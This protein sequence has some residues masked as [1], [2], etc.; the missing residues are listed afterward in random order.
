ME[1]HTAP[2]SKKIFN[3]KNNIFESHLCPGYCPMHVPCLASFNP[4]NHLVSW[5]PLCLINRWENRSSELFSNLP[6]KIQPIRTKKGSDSA[7]CY[8]AV[9]TWKHTFPNH[10]IKNK[11]INT[12]AIN[13]TLKHWTRKCLYFDLHYRRRRNIFWGPVPCT[14]KNYKCQ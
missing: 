11:L 10:N 8:V 5:K 9:T 14:V 6:E 7:A 13:S 1:N 2:K 12:N 4:H 3:E